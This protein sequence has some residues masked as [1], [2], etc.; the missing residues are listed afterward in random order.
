MRARRP[1]VRAAGGLLWLLDYVSRAHPHMALCATP[2]SG[3]AAAGGDRGRENSHRTR[4]NVSEVSIDAKSTRTFNCKQPVALWH[5]QA[6]ASR[7]AQNRCAGEIRLP[8]DTG[9]KVKHTRRQQQPNRRDRP[10]GPA[11][12]APGAAP[13]SQTGRVLRVPTSASLRLNSPRQYPWVSIPCLCSH[14]KPTGWDGTPV[15][16]LFSSERLKR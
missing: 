10:T 7:T 4:T 11:E 2:H 15:P 5:E 12:P 13:D 8:R 14:R 3:A 9:K 1:A 6:A 16:G